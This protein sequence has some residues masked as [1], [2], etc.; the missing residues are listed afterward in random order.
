[1]NRFEPINLDI[2]SQKECIN[3]K[4]LRNEVNN[5]VN[6]IKLIFLSFKYFL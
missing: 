2:L 6:I 5:K 4:T 3:E 1:M